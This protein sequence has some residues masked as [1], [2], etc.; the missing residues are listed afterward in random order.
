MVSCLEL[1][2]GQPRR[3]ASRLPGPSA[4]ATAMSALD[5]SSA[6]IPSQGTLRMLEYSRPGVGR[7]GLV[8]KRGLVDWGNGGLTGPRRC[9]AWDWSLCEIDPSRQW[10]RLAILATGA[11]DTSP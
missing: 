3:S 6:E 8:G 5:V 11:L 9:R 10:P 7:I 1:R 4:A 2:H